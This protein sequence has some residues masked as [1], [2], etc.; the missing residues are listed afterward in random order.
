MVFLL[1]LLCRFRLGGSRKILRFLLVCCS[2]LFLRL[3]LGLGFR[4][5][6]LGFVGLGTC[7]VFLC[8]LKVD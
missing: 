2:S 5:L 8:L 3:L 1:G 7:L 4:L 6:F